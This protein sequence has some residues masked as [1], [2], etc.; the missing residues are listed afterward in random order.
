MHGSVLDKL[1]IAVSKNTAKL[2]LL[3]HYSKNS[4][5]SQCKIGFP[6]YITRVSNP[7]HLT[8][9]TECIAITTSL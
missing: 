7:E 6:S 5:Q 2:I 3:G 1:N 9:C 8:K 4:N